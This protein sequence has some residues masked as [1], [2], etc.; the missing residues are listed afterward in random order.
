MILLFIF[1]PDRM[2]NS[3]KTFLRFVFDDRFVSIPELDLVNIIENETDAKCPILLCSTPG[4]DASNKIELLARKL[5]KRIKAIAIGSLK[6]FDLVEKNFHNKIKAGEWLVIKNV[7]LTPSWLNEPEKKLHLNEPNPKFRLFLTM[8]FNPKIPA[9]VLRLS[10]KFVFELPRVS[11]HSHIRS[12][13]N[14]FVST[15][16]EKVPLEKCRLHFLLAWFHV[17][18]GERLRYVPFGWSKCYKFNEADQLCAIDALDEWLD[19]F[20]KDKSNH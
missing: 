5:N 17:V 20:G 18:I 19:L 3:V 12:Y 11:K 16:S 9:N 15:R 8:E 13:S 6:G 2:I 1:R 4:H 10:K 7:H 14:V